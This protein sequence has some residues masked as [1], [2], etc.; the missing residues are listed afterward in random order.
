MHQVL[1][2]LVLDVH[3]NDIKCSCSRNIK[4]P[5]SQSIPIEYETSFAMATITIKEMLELTEDH[6]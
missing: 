2:Q 3:R 6:I 1:F 4:L 5:S